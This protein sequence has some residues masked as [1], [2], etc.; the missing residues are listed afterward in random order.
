MISLEVERLRARALA[1]RESRLLKLLC[2]AATDLKVPFV[3]RQAGC[4]DFCP[5]RP[6]FTRVCIG[7]G[8]PEAS[9]YYET[10]NPAPTPKPAHTWLI[11]DPASIAPFYQ[12]CLNWMSPGLSVGTLLPK[13]VESWLQKLRCP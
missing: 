5:E 12:D 1:A 6:D 3:I 9:T 4:V 11:Y 8:V 10:I 7:V 13:D 2:G